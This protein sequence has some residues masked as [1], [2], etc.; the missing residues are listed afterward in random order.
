[1]TRTALILT[2]ENHEGP[3]LLGEILDGYGFAQN[4]I[5]TPRESIDGI[6]PLVPDLLLVMGGSMAVY[7]ADD[8]PFLKDEVAFLQKRLGADRPVLG[9]CLG[10]QLMAAA[11][12][13]TVS[14]GAAGKEIGWNPLI[15]TE[16]GKTHALAHLD[17]AKTNML[18]WHGDSFALP[19]GAILLA[20]SS[21]YENQ[22]YSYGRKAL[23]LQCHPEITP[24]QFGA[25]LEECAE[26][27]DH[28]VLVD[29]AQTLA[30]QT[31]EYMD[32]MN[33]QTRKFFT[34]WLKDIK[35]I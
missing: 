9:I 27:V 2:H 6:D 28:S 34:Q 19:D 17:G 29:N 25:W 26:E 32:I 23:A 22:A 30:R 5:F 12:G 15:L 35:L 21:L 7:E 3:G 1:M 24:P 20:S 18:H 11:L 8:Y 14:R 31:R 10:A 13:R 33:A 4:I 16:A